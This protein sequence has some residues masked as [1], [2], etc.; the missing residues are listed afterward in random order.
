MPRLAP[1]TG[2]TPPTEGSS[3]RLEYDLVAAT[4]QLTDDA[5]L[6]DGKNQISGNQIAYDLTRQVVTAGA[7]QGGQ[8]RMRIT[9]QQKPAPPVE[10]P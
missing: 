8:V 3:Q 10:T 1:G 6:S 7:T 5:Y 4:I 2:G 9:P